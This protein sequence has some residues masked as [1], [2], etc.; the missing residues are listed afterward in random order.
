[1]MRNV[2]FFIENLLKKS[3]V[4]CDH[5]FI[6]INEKELQKKKRTSRK[7]I[8]IYQKSNYLGIFYKNVDELKFLVVNPVNCS[9]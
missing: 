6:E 5:Y 7:M 8:K 3:S 2:K 1:M 4:I 9:A